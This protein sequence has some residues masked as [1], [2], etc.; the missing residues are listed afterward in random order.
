M[1]KITI[2]FIFFSFVCL[3]QKPVHAKLSYRNQLKKEAKSQIIQLK[4][5]SLLVRLMTKEM[6][7]SALRKYGKNSEADAMQK[8]QADFNRTI[9]KAFRANFTVCPV[10]FFYSTYSQDVK[11]QQFNKVIFL[12]DSL[13]EDLTI[14]LKNNS[15]LVADF[16]TIEQ[17]TSTFYSHETYEPN[18][19]FGMK[20]V[21]RSYGGPSFGFDALI[22]RSEKLIQLRRPFPYYVRT[23]NSMPNA[24]VINRAVTK[25]NMNLLKYA[26]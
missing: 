5:G 2:F 10:Y 22:I 23:R 8:K 11:Q 14:Q 6:S 3:S 21:K 26:L 15:F 7:I 16:S 18:S 4:N 19:N 1:N 12:N 17:D 25:M 13:V 9:I 20:T 24:R